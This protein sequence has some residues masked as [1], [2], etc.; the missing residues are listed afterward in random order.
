MMP[1]V[2]ATSLLLAASDNWLACPTFWGI[3]AGAVAL[4]LLVPGGRWSN[5]WSRIAGGVLAAVSGVLFALDLPLL[6]N[7]GTQIVFWLIA[8][9]TLGSAV[10]MISAKSPVYSALWFAMSLVGVAGLFFMQGAQFLGGATIVVYAGAI[11]VTFLFVIMLAQPEGHSVYDRL[12]WG[13]LPR[14]V[15]IVSAALL[16]GLI[17]AGLTRLGDA[18]DLAAN[19]AEPAEQLV[20][21]NGVLHRLHM[22]SL[23]RELFSGQLIAVEVA[24]TLLLAALV[25]AIAIAIHGKQRSQRTTRENLVA[26]GNAP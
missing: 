22:A 12:S 25:G 10:A 18:G 2:W 11:V 9:V 15:A 13:W 14:G 19:R 24:G 17:A 23:G 1:L 7:L 20:A 5:T 3:A 21:E 26:G 8:L 6:G 16:L 4:W